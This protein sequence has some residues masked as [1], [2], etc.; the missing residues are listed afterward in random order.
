M[1]SMQHVYNIPTSSDV[2][3]GHESA[4]QNHNRQYVVQEIKAWQFMWNVY[5]AIINTQLS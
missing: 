5:R 1:T 4:I 2:P 3:V